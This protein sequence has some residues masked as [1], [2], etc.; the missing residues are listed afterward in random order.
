MWKALEKN[1]K[2]GDIVA[3][4][5]AGYLYDDC[6]IGYDIDFIETLVDF[7]NKRS[8]SLLILADAPKLPRFGLDCSTPATTALCERNR[9]EAM[10]TTRLKRIK[11]FTD[12]ARERR[13]T[14]Y[15]SAAELFCTNKLCGAYIPGT[16]VLAYKDLDHWTTEASLYV[17]PF[18]HCFMESK[19]LI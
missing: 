17:A 10:S 16:S 5:T 15:F 12:F 18:L 19:N 14:Y 8:A 6:R 1:V 3:K 2:P 7:V 11:F 9:S 13:N 4:V